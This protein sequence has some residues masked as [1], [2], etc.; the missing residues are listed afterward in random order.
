[1]DVDVDVDVDEE[2]QG[3]HEKVTRRDFEEED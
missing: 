3:A 2:G 1:V